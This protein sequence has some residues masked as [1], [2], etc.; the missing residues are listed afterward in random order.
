[1]SGEGHLAVGTHALVRADFRVEGPSLPTVGLPFTSWMMEG[2][3]EMTDEIAALNSH[4]QSS[5][6]LKA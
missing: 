1:M 6:S 3:I 2:R 4:P 5:F